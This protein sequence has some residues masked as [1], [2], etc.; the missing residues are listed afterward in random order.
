MFFGGGGGGFPSGFAEAFGGGGGA[1]SGPVENDEYYDL[2]GVSKDADASKIKKAYR[3]LAVKHHP[4]KGGDPETFKQI[5]EAFEVLSNDEKRSLYDQGG[6]EAVEQGGVSGGD[7]FSS[8]F[9]GGRRRAKPGE[10]KG[11]SVSHTLKVTLEQCYRGDVRKL[12]LGRVVIDKERGVSKCTECEGGT[13]IRTIRR[14]PM[15][16]QMQQPCQVPGC[17]RGYVCHR[18]NVK[19]LL[20][21]HIPRGAPNGH[22]LTFYEKGDEIPDGAAGDVHIVLDVQDSTNTPE[23]YR[24]KGCDLYVKRQISLV[25]ALCGFEMEI[26]HLDG[27]KMI[28]KSGPGDV[29]KPVSYDPF[30]AEEDQQEWEEVQNTECQLQ[31][32]AQA[33]L[34]D[35]DK[36][37][38]VIARGQLRGKNISAF[39]TSRGQTTFFQ[40]TPS[41]IRDASTSRRGCTLYVMADESAGAEKR[42]MKCIPEQ[43]MPLPSNPMLVGNMFLILDIVFPTQ[44]PASAISAV[45]AA[46]PPPMNNAVETDSHEVHTLSEKDPVQ[47]FKETDIPD[48]NADDEE[49]EE[50]RGQSVQCAQQ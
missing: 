17:N 40:G 34:D 46:L 24:R 18:S 33:E 28:V 2:L 10:R 45:K 31:P 15:I 39:Q 42:M 27:R 41:E 47:S 37:K 22:K 3:K 7:P 49:D 23:E 36:L 20:E 32:F 29:T 19:E 35:V 43:G 21:V 4:D 1:P 26:T 44:L 13:V 25:E 50:M 5:T 6:K 9:G 8:M 11:K 48:E 14:G 16:Q 38:Q 30:A 12:R